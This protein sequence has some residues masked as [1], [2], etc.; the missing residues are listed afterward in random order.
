MIWCSSRH[1][2][3]CGPWHNSGT[4]RRTRCRGR[5][6]TLVELVVVLAVIVLVAAITLPAIQLARES[7]HRVSCTNKLRQ[8]GIALHS[9][10]VEG[11]VFP[12]IRVYGGAMSGG[13]APAWNPSVMLLPHVGEETLYNAINLSLS[14]QDHANSTLTCVSPGIF[15]CPSDAA[16]RG[17]AWGV[18]SYKACGGSGL[19]PGGFSA[20]IVVTPESSADG[21]FATMTGMRPADVLGGL[22]HTAAMSEMVHGGEMAPGDISHQR[23]PSVGLTYVIFVTPAVQQQIIDQC[24]NVAITGFSAVHTSGAPWCSDLPYTHLF[25]PGKASCWAGNVGDLYSPITASSRH[26]GGVNLL[27][28]DGHVRW[29]SDAIDADTWRAVGSRLRSDDVGF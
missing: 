3:G 29:V 21:L 4:R 10:Q 17:N 1:G 6:I 23:V 9:Y 18:S 12:P 25:T 27:L 19:Y 24:E 11:G 14:F 2:A 22:S 16:P 8:L 15:L 5:A 7:A 13:A 26:R 20:R 28:A